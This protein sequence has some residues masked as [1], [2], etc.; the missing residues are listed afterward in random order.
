M[1]KFL[2]YMTN[3]YSVGLYCEDTSDIYHSAHGAL[4]EAYEKFISP[5]CLRDNIR[6][7]DICYGI[8]YNTKVLINEA[9]RTGKE[10]I[11][12]DCVD[13]NSMLM[14]ISPFINSRI[15][16]LDR[17]FR[18]SVLCKNVSGY[19]EAYKIISSK[20]NVSRLGYKLSSAVNLILYMSLRDSIRFD[21]KNLLT[22]SKNQV[23]FDKDMLFIDKILGE[24]RV[25]SI[26]NK[27]LS[28]NLH[29]IYYQYISKRYIE[30]IEHLYN[31]LNLRFFCQ[32]IREYLKNHNDKYDIIL[33]DGFTPSKCPCI[34]SQDFFEK[35]YELMNDNAQLVTYNSSAVVRAAMLNAKLNIGNILDKNNNVIGTFASKNKNLIKNPLSK[36]QLG[37]LAT[38]AGTPYRDKDLK[39]TN[40]QII[41]NRNIEL[42]QST[43]ESSSKYLKRCKN[44]I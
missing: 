13:T 28:T 19:K 30:K 24:N 18:G 20:K 42:I 40:E 14:Q 10:N 35:L 4:S 23:F 41:Q 25:Q 38:K 39:Q 7:L 36:K 32:D 31:R 9:L 29:N 5:L 8:G 6:V 37:L 11:S 33:L 2:P 43:L 16:F 21:V 34:W 44:E 3:D 15:S 12:I 1:D 27:I 26:Q 17:I 22:N